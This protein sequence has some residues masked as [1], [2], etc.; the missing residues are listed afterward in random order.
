MI[1]TKTKT[2]GAYEAKTHLASLLDQVAKG[3][4]I[5]ITRR[6]RPVARLVP[7]ETEKADADLYDRIMAFRNR[8]APLPKGETTRDL[9]Q[10]GRRI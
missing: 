1:T 9:I 7:I 4:E 5:V 8:V 2:I 10:A 3:R 6:E